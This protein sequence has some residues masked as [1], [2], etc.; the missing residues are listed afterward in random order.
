LKYPTV[1]AAA[2]AAAAAASASPELLYRLADR[3]TAAAQPLYMQLLLP[4]SQHKAGV[5]TNTDINNLLQK[6]PNHTSAMPACPCL[7][8]MCSQQ[9]LSCRAT[10]LCVVVR[11]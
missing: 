2:A 7:T 11:L 5:H 1:V 4:V 3:L 9:G 6:K 8:A 10:V